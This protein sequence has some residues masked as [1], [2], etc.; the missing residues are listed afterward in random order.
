ML[1][2]SKIYQRWLDERDCLD[3][4]DFVQTELGYHNRPTYTGKIVTCVR[5]IVN[6]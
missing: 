6:S 1:S 4:I 3:R 2:L 5:T